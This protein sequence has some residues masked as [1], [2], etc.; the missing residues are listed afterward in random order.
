L[1]LVI[2][3]HSFQ[4]AFDS[5]NRGIL[6]NKLL[7]YGIDCK[8][9]N[10]LLNDRGQYVQIGKHVSETKFTTCG[11]SQGNSSSSLFFS[12]YINDLPLCIDN[13]MITLFADDSTIYKSEGIGETERLKMSL[14]KDLTN[15]N[16]WLIKNRV[17]LN[18][19]KTQCMLIGKKNSVKYCENFEISING[20]SVVK[21]KSL[22]I[23]GVIIDQHLSFHEQS[24]KVLSKCYKSLSMLYPLKR[25]ITTENKIMLVNA[26]VFSTLSYGIC[27]WG[28]NINKTNLNNID[29]LI[30]HTAKYVLNKMKYDGISE[31]IN[32]T[33]EW[34][35]FKNKLVYENL[36][37]AY[38][39][40]FCNPHKFIN[41]YLN[42]TSSD[43]TCTRNNCYKIPLIQ[44][45]GSWGKK[46][47]KYLSAFQ[48]L[49]LP[50]DL[51]SC[52]TSFNIFKR[53]LLSYLLTQ[54]INDYNSNN[55]DIR[56]LSYINDV[57]NDVIANSIY[58]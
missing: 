20:T 21:V 42:F 19:G 50:D 36:C 52:V 24:D 49:Q 9:I 54:Q 32:L 16:N 51:V 17:K 31:D 37:C 41:N 33:L 38:K 10:S 45:S 55:S 11:I 1:V 23:L 2:L 18:V 12:I 26:Y 58:C 15:I 57:I 8:L 6:I 56:D 27:V 43:V 29:K 35:Y 46:S 48:W 7:W 44:C 13:S 39:M 25:I 14:E 22:K 28:N 34:L 3:L 40:N 4:K 30:K 5:V 53:K 47:F